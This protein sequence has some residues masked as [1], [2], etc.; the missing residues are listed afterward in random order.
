MSAGMGGSTRG[1]WSGDEDQFARVARAIRRAIK[2]RVDLVDDE[3]RPRQEVLALET[4]DAAHPKWMNEALLPAIGVGDV[5]DEL[6][7][8]DL[9]DQVALQHSV[10]P[11]DRPPIGQGER[12]FL[13]RLGPVGRPAQIV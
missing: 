6:A 1:L 7:G 11:D 13:V 5:I 4:K 8:I 9:V 3:A 2:V 12:W 10:P